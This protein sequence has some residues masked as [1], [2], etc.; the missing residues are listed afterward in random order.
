MGIL[1]HYI[2]FGMVRKLLAGCVFTI[3]DNLLIT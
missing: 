2:T 3:V 1:E